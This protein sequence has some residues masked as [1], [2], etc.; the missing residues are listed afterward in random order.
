MTDS[1]MPIIRQMHE[2]DGD[3]ERATILLAVPDLV[4]AKYADVFV[5]ACRRAR[6]D[7]G[8]EFIAVRLSALRAVRDGFGNLPEPI[9]LHW[10]AMRTILIGHRDALGLP[11]REA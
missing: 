9:A 6:F 8:E 10:K 3:A 1:M 11:A 7:D 4:L 5:E 2:A